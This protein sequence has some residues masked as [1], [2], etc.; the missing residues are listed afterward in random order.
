MGDVSV[1]DVCGLYEKGEI[2]SGCPLR[3]S[4]LVSCGAVHSYCCKN[5]CC[6]CCGSWSGGCDDGGGG[7]SIIAR[8]DG[9]VTLLPAK[10]G[11]RREKRN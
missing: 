5:C 8:A 9:G 11:L 1:V 4:E 6:C 2:K 7:G 3:L 10:E